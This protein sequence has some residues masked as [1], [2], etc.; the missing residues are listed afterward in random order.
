MAQSI[1]TMLAQGKTDD[2]NLRVF[3]NQAIMEFTDESGNIIRK[4]V[5]V[6]IE[7]TIGENDGGQ[8]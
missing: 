1:E 2:T 3:D 5:M 7:I 8:P 6:N 4:K